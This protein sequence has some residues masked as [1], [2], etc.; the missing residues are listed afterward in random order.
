MIA[1]L[2]TRIYIIFMVPGCSRQILK[3]HNLQS[4]KQVSGINIIRKHSFKH[5]ISA[6]CALES[7]AE[8]PSL[9][10]GLFVLYYYVSNL[11]MLDIVHGRKE[12]V[13]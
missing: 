4:I 12:K 6:A 11:I 10:M 1:Q 2:D 8:S 7:L 9:P 13:L 3:K 5:L